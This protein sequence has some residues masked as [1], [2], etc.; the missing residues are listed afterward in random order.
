M[1]SG[2]SFEVN[3]KQVIHF[4]LGPVRPWPQ[5]NGAK[6]G[7]VLVH[8]HFDAEP[9]VMVVRKKLIHNVKPGLSP[10]VINGSYVG[11]MVKS[12]LTPQVP[13]NV[14]GAIT[15]DDT[16]ILVP[17]RRLLYNSITER[18]RQTSSYVG[19][20]NGPSVARRSRSRLRRLRNRGSRQALPRVI[21]TM[22]EAGG[23]P[24][25]ILS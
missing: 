8:P 2:M 25:R 19:G 23:T 1:Q 13:Q 3:P 15:R 7:L 4:T 6:H 21:K 14:E 20:R 5:I 9:P 16:R 10:Q 22:S 12:L 17:K 18:L 11:E 24:R